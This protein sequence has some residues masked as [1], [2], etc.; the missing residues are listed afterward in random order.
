MFGRELAVDYLM[1]QARGATER[2]AETRAQVA[3]LA[4]DV[5]YLPL[6][7]AVARANA[8]R[9]NWTF[10]Q[11]RRHLAEMIAR[12][13]PWAVGYPRFIAA[14]FALAIDKAKEAR[15]NAERLL[16]IAAYLAPDR[17]PLVIVPNDVLSE[18]ERGEAVAALAEVSLV[19]RETLEDG[20]PGISVHRLVQEVM[21]LQLGTAADEMAAR[22]TRLVASAYPRDADDVRSWSACR[23]LEGLAVAVLAHASETGPSA[24]NTSLL[25]KLYAIHLNARAEHAAAELLYRRALA[26][27]ENR[28]GPDHPDVADSLNNLAQLLHQATNRLGEAEALMRRAL[29]I[30]ERSVGAEHSSVAVGL[31]NLAQLLQDTNRIAEAEPL[32]LRA[33]AIDQTTYGPEH[34]HVAVGLNNLAELFWAT[35]RPADAE[36]L[37]RR[38][39]AI[40]ERSFGPEHPS[41]A[42]DLNNL[43]L[44]LQNTNRLAEAEPL[45]RRAVTLNEKCFGPDHLQVAFP[46]NNLAQLLQDT[47]SLKQAEPLMRRA[48]AIL[49]TRLGAEHPRTRMVLNNYEELR[50]ALGNAA[51]D[52]AFRATMLSKV[53]R[54]RGLFVRLFGSS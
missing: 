11:C 44:V 34:P 46:V 38:A 40:D 54:Q 52:R 27:D 36:P 25:L 2:P 24:E 29:A 21:R 1:A 51:A 4:N 37:M 10:G 26:I 53:A 31:S 12:E 35:N 3:A 6:A 33:L 50:A 9:M 15:P 22:A 7:L 39:L 20:S 8:W 17:I 13:P 41:V 45:Y 49:E 43:A 19:T 32:H 16:Q 48:V 28:F 30:Y 18:I 23:R 42:R 5:G 47:N 14:T